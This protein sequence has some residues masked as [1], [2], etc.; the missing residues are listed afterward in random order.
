MGLIQV[1]CEPVSTTY[2]RLLENI[3]INQLNHNIETKKVVLTSEKIAKDTPKI[4][5]ST[6]LDTCNSVVDESYSGTKE[7]I[8]CSTL[9]HQIEG[10]NPFLIKIDVEGFEEDVLAGAKNTLRANSLVAVI[11]EGQTESINKLFR[12]YG[13]IDFDYAPTDRTLTLKKKRTSNRI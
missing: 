8:E 10:I 5:F 3:S 7:M 12:E 1:A 13:F 4:L 2:Q 6:D 11:I 9:D